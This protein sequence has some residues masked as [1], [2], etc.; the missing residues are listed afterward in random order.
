MSTESSTVAESTP[1]ETVST[2]SITPSTSPASGLDNR[3]E[4]KLA[5][6]RGNKPEAHSTPASAQKPEAPSPAPATNSTGES[7][8]RNEEGQEQPFRRPRDNRRFDELTKRLHEREATI[9]ELR[10]QVQASS[11]TQP[12]KA[13]ADYGSDE[14]YIADLARRSASSE[15]AQS[16]LSALENRQHREQRQAWD[17]QVAESVANPQAFHADLGQA[18][19]ANLIDDATQE[20]AMSSPVGARMLEVFLSKV[21][22]SSWRAEW[23]RMPAIKKGIALHDLEQRVQG[24]N[25]AHAQQNVAPAAPAPSLTPSKGD[26]TPGTGGTL[27]SAFESKLDRVRSQWRR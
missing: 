5:A 25:I 27:Q 8:G 21:K 13:R 4:S 10:R 23:E 14:E 22:D 6:V 9:A 2:A 12:T 7:K 18:L 20:Y 17:E 11:S 26:R 15:L 16:Q 1:A 19:H 24:T 3:F